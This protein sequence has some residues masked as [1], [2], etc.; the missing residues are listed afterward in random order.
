MAIQ[1]FIEVFFRVK[2]AGSENAARALVIAYGGFDAT[3][4]VRLQIDVGTLRHEIQW[5][6]SPEW[7]S[8]PSGYDSCVR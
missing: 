2:L 4:D 3:L 1:V 5:L 6:L 7:P 8:P